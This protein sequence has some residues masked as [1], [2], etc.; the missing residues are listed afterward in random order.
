MAGVPIGSNIWDGVLKVV[1]IY[2]DNVYMGKTLD[3]TELIKEEDIKDIFYAQEGT[4][5]SDKIPTGMSYMVKA[6]LAEITTAR[7]EKL[8][9]GITAN[10]NSVKIDRE[11]YVSLRDRA[12]VL[13]IVASD[14]DGEEST[15][16]NMRLIFYKAVPVTTGNFVYGP[17]NQRVL[18]VEFYIF[19]DSAEGGYGFSGTASSVGMNDPSA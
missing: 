15:D 12:K 6:S 1:H 9:R 3:N 8:I 14:P 17:D 13:K 16:P 2:F 11:I 7:M 10:G 18:E 4:K 5:P 19:R